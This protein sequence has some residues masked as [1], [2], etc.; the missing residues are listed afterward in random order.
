MLP[1]WAIRNPHYRLSTQRTATEREIPAIS[2]APYRHAGQAL[3][4]CKEYAGFVVDVESGR[5]G[6]S[7]PSP[8]P[9][10][11][12]EGAYR[13]PLAR[14]E[15][16]YRV[17]L[18]RG[19]G[20][21]RARWARGVRAIRAPFAQGVRAGRAP[22]ARGVGACR[23]PWARGVGVI[24]APLARRVGSYRA[25]IRPRNRSPLCALGSTPQS[26]FRTSIGSLPRAWK[27]ICLP[28]CLV[29]SMRGMQNGLS[30][31]NCLEPDP[32]L[33]RKEG[34]SLPR[35]PTPARL[36][37]LCCVCLA[38]PSTSVGSRGT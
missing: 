21:H 6:E 22:L 31:R 23:P 37:K 11:Q 30:A 28:T 32:Y 25:P 35:Q 10:P 24:R 9:S 4:N 8:Q 17:P 16:A 13:A 14:G 29:Q 5:S 27:S 2:G 38:P 20:A 18:A 3:C 26:L 1:P 34:E 7:P 19:E 33:K 12:G 15:G 36:T